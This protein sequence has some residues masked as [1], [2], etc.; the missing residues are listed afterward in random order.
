MVMLADLTTNINGLKLSNPIITASGTF[1]YANEF[2]DFINVRNL[3]A[4][5]TKAITLEPRPGNNWKRIMETPAGMIN[6]IGLENMGVESFMK[7]VLP[8]LE[9]EKIPFIVNVAGAS[10]DE[11]LKLAEIC[12]NNK[13]KAIE[14]NLSC[15]NV[16]AGCMEFGISEAHLY[17]LIKEV[18]ACYS[19]TLIA[20]LTPNVTAIEKIAI[21][22]QNAGADA[23]SA[24]NTLKA[25]AINLNY[26]NGKFKME[27]VNG[28]LSGRAIK[29][30]ALRAIS[31]IRENVDI[32]IIGMGGISSL[33]DILEFIAVGA[34]A[35]QIGTANFTH[36][37]ISE[38]LVNELAEFISTNGFGSFEEL[39]RKLREDIKNE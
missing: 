34:D 37:E 11:Y 15:P 18:R 6:S 10:M 39:K 19:G 28:G 13:I 24:I 27:R 20:K 3:G 8:L 5:V 33:N 38:Q 22:A 14:L 17:A 16:K 2:D 30:V 1:G 23:I 4:I 32:P 21:A 12:E 26:V 36:P 25:T 31:T 29:P 9:K 35:V 7:N